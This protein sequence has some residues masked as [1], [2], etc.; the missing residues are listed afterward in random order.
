GL[1]PINALVDIT[2]YISFDLGRPLHVFDAD[3]IKGNLRVRCGREG[4]QLQALNGKVYNLGVKDCVI[5]DE[6][7]VVSI[8]GIMGGER[9]S[10]D[11]TTRRVIIESALWDAQSIAQT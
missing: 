10:C 1:R 8:A 5:A 11:E 2:N 7:G 6:E 4:E 3:K 9:T